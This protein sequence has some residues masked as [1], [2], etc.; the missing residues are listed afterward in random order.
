MRA[1]GETR[2]ENLVLYGKRGRVRQS[3]FRT[4]ND[5][6]M[7]NNARRGANMAIEIRRLPLVLKCKGTGRSTHY[8]E[9][10]DGLWPPAV[11]LGPRAVGWVSHE[12]DA[13][14]AARVAGQSDGEIRALVASLVAARSRKSA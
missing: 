9:I 6:A 12:C 2:Q 8:Q 14:L 11:R 13:V 1:Q 3:E 10:A 4:H 7:F 5:V